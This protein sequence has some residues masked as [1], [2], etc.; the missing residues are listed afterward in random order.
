MDKAVYP[1]RF[2]CRVKSQNG[3]QITLLGP[4]EFQHE[5]YFEKLGTYRAA[6]TCNSIF[7]YTVAK[8][9]EIPWTGAVLI[10]PRISNEE[11]ELIGFKHNRNVIWVEECHSVERAIEVLND[12]ADVTETISANGAELMRK[13][14]TAYQRLDYI[15]RLV[16]LIKAGGFTPED[17]KDCFLR[18]R[19]GVR[20]AGLA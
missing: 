18:H 3:A 9:F 16:R 7:E 2:E 10:A 4:N 8:Y 19:Q 11:S 20:H 6:I 15:E 13:S 14:H 12:L 1:F 17:A 5:N